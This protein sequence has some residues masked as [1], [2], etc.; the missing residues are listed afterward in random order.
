MLHMPITAKHLF[1]SCKRGTSQNCVNVLAANF[2]Q[3]QNNQ[4]QI[5]KN[6][7][8]PTINV[9]RVRPPSS[10]VFKSVAKRVF[11]DL[12]LP[13]PGTCCVVIRRVYIARQESRKIWLCIFCVATI[14]QSPYSSLRRP[15]TRVATNC[16][17]PWHVFGDLLP[18]LP[19][20]PFHVLSLSQ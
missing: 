4:E 17:P 10:L 1:N 6:M 7:Q 14:M 18:L 13:N 15:K 3:I 16:I 8:N 2:V 9:P 12:R 5:Y 11:G 20:S 19:L